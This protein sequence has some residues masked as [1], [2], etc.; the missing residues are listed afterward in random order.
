MSH[1]RFRQIIYLEIEKH[2]VELAESLLE[3]AASFE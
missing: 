3:A 1:S 2:K